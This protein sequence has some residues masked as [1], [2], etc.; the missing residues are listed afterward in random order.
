M[1]SNWID[2]MEQKAEN[3]ATMAA[4]MGPSDSDDQDNQKSAATAVANTKAQFAAMKSEAAHIQSI[5]ADVRME[6]QGLVIMT[7]TE[8][9]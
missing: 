9:K 6:D 2:L 5:S 7:H 1:Y 8:L 4:A 3:A